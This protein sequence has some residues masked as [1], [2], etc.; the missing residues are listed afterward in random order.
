MQKTLLVTGG[1]RGIG[2]ACALLGAQNGW[3]VGVSYRED[4]KAADEVVG[5]IA[6]QGGRAVAL[7]G[8][9]SVEADTVGMFDAA[10]KALGPLTAVIANAGV[11]APAMR[12][13]DMSAER[14]RH[15]FE[16]NGLGAFLTAREAARRMSQSSGGAGGSIVLMSSAAARLGSPNLYIDYAASKG[17]VDTLTLGLA[18]ELGPEG[19][20][21]NA[22]RPGM[23]DTEI[24]ASGGDPGRARSVGTTVPLG[25]PGTAE[26]VAAAAIWLISDAASYVTGAL[27]DVSGGR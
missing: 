27:L 18:K 20:R 13:A 19:V 24:H 3:A 26:E 23:I 21:V 15:V 7:K 16:V 5:I 22:V 4:A 14:M 11:V 9:V 10:T 25:R 17:A 1:S 12:L 2:R 6:K 8:D